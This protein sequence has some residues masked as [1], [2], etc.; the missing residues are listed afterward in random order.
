MASERDLSER[1]LQDCS[2]EE[3]V[4]AF[5]DGRS[6]AFRALI[7]RYERPLFN[8]LYRLLGSR[9]DADD[10]FQ[11]TFLRVYKALPRFDTSR[12][13]KPWLYTIAG[14]LVKNVYRSRSVRKAL[15]LDREAEEDG[16]SSDLAATIAGLEPGPLQ[17]A[18]GEERAELVRAAVEDL[19]PKG[20]QALVLFYFEGFSY[21]EIA[22][23]A[24]V[25]LGTV[26]SRIHNAT[27]RLLKVLGQHQETLEPGSA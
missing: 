23:I 18:L 5:L 19:P 2:D 12:R 7:G 8:H 1:D 26:K 14:N 24:S 20:R 21:E 13:F 27:V 11:E 9:A 3:L 10:A 16:R 22:G 17:R 25:P 6:P 15:S 4:Q